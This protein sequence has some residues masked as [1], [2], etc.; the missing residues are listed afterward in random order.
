[1]LSGMARKLGLLLHAI[2]AVSLVYIA[3]RLSIQPPEVAQ[4][5]QVTRPPE[6]PRPTQPMYV[7]PEAMA[8]AYFLATGTTVL[9]PLKLRHASLF[10]E[11]NHPLHPWARL[12]APP[13]YNPKDE[14]RFQYALISSFE[15]QD[16]SSHHMMVARSRTPTHARH[17]VRISRTFRARI[18]RYESISAKRAFW[19]TALV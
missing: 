2:I 19:E 3:I 1:M 8:A 6:I 14:S 13:T 9:Q 17:Q 7:S 10:R 16:E 5:A 4:P 12:K 11:G 15:P 18:T